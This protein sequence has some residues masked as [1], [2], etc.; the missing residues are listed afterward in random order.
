MKNNEFV[1]LKSVNKI[2]GINAQSEIKNLK[3]NKLLKKYIGIDLYEHVILNMKGKKYRKRVHR[4]M[5]EAFLQNC[6]IV[7]HIDGNRSNNVLSNLQALTNSENVKK[8]YQQN[9]YI[10][11]HTCRGIWIIIEDKKT[12]HKQF[13]KSLK[14]CEK[15][16]GIDRHRIKFILENKINNLTQYNFYYDE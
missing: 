4:L 12:K 10:N 6:K 9:K 16:T 13:F 8:A 15:A 3:T 1:P 14:A 2:F 11:P 5:A 7:D